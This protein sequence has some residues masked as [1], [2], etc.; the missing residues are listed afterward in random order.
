MK[1]DGTQTATVV[2][3]SSGIDDPMFTPDD[4][5]ILYVTYGTPGAQLKHSFNA[6]RFSS[7]DVR[8]HSLS[9]HHYGSVG[10]VDRGIASINLDGSNATLIVTDTIYEAEIFNSTLYY[11]L[12]N[13][14]IGFDQIM[15]ANVD[16]TGSVSISDGTAEDW[17]GL[18]DC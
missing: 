1:A 9:L 15:K 14:S 13:S 18:C 5:H 16:G 2:T 17:L 4:K 10:P 7:H 6:D 3:Q 11:T 8:T 12:Y